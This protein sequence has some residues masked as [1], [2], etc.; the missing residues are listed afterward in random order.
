MKTLV[1]R[2]Q[3]ILEYSATRSAAPLA[4][5]M[6][7]CKRTRFR[8]SDLLWGARIIFMNESGQ[9]PLDLLCSRWLG[10]AEVRAED[11]ALPRKAAESLRQAH[12]QM[13][14]GLSSGAA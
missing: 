1:V 9:R 3:V 2:L 10:A 6:I 5:L 11:A 14:P 7:S 12:C 8:W 13:F 4:G